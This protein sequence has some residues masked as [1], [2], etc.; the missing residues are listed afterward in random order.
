MQI[1]GK[2]ALVTGAG[3]GIGRGI[4]RQLVPAGE[5]KRQQE[6]PLGRPDV[7]RLIPVDL[8]LFGLSEE[9]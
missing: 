6:V 1:Q 9:V 5:L 3:Y 2:T 8:D 4:A 7:M